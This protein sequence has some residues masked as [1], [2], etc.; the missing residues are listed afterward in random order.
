M[1]VCSLSDPIRVSFFLGPLKMPTQLKEIQPSS[2]HLLQLKLQEKVEHGFQG[3]TKD[4]QNS[5][6]SGGTFTL[7]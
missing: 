7:L 3:G 2:G 1:Y 4:A 5:Q 6:C